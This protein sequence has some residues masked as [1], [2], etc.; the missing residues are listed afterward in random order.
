MASW[1][2]T[3]LVDS[4]IS[5]INVMIVLLVITS[6]WFVHKVPI[7]F[8]KSKTLKI[9][10][11]SLIVTIPYAISLKVGLGKYIASYWIAF[12]FHTT[13]LKFLERYIKSKMINEND[14]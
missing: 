5:N 12:G 10:V 14:G 8:V 1:S 9:I 2:Y 13:I 3:E 7:V 4:V 6:G 11:F